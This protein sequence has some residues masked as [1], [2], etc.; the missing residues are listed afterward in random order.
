[1]AVIIGGTLAT[2]KIYIPLYEHIFTHEAY[3]PDIGSKAFM[4]E[5]VSSIWFLLL[6]MIIP[7]LL[8]KLL[9]VLSGF[10]WRY[11]RFEKT[12]GI[13]EYAGYTIYKDFYNNHIAFE[14]D[15][16]LFSDSKK[17]KKFREDYYKNEIHTEKTRISVLRSVYRL[18]II[19]LYWSAGLM[20]IYISL[21]PAVLFSFGGILLLYALSHLFTYTYWRRIT[22]ETLA[23]A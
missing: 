18:L 3:D 19:C 22:K 10:R 15:R 12:D 2:Y 6:Y 13:K 8:M 20:Y 11:V 16:L 9:R 1:M 21:V 23:S 14:S 7:P 17:Y 5:L 4:F